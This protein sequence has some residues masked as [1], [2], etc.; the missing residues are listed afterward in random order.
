[1]TYL[2]LPYD[3]AAT[4]TEM[5]VDCR[6]VGDALRLVGRATLAERTAAAAVRPAPSLLFEDFP[7]EVRKPSLT[8]SEAASRLARAYYQD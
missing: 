8:I 1:M 4:A 5:S 2:R 6:A 3:E 7:R